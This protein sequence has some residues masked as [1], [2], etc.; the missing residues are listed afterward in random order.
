M[1]HFHPVAQRGDWVA[2]IWL[3]PAIAGGFIGL[4]ADRARAVRWR[5]YGEFEAPY[6][7]QK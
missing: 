7:I 1:S 2:F 4:R 5:A 6:T 3:P